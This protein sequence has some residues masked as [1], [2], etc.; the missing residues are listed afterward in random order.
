[1]GWVGKLLP[2]TPFDHEGWKK[3]DLRE[4]MR[5]GALSWAD[6]G[7]GWLTLSALLALAAYSLVL[8]HAAPSTVMH[9]LRIRPCWQ[10][11][12]PPPSLHY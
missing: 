6:V 3:G 2:L 9:W 8:I 7:F 5:I 4:K 10:M 11:L 12:L 1:M